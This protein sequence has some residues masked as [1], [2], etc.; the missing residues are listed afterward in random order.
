MKEDP[1]VAEIRAV[2]HR[3]SEEF[4]HDTRVLVEHYRKLEMK[5]A[6]RMLPSGQFME[7]G[8]PVKA[9]NG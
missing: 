6:D 4:G 8:P 9:A 5:Y 7:S 2:R 3:I 1:L